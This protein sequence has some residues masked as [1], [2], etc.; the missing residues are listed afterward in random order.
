ME[1]NSLNSPPPDDAQLEAWLRNNASLAP[2]PDDGFTSR[3]LAT[4]PAPV[5]RQSVQRAWFCIAGALVGLVVAALKIAS[6]P[7]FAL[8]VPAISP[9]AA[10]GLEQLADPRLL[11]AVAVTAAS[12]A[13]AL[14]PRRRGLGPW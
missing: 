13:F 10:R 3:V 2:L 9:D 11:V 14:R 1:P 6:A 4:L 8:I 7:D 5:A 12:L